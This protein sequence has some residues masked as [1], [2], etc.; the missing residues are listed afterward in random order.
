MRDATIEIVSNVIKHP[1]ADRL[2][3]CTVLGYQCVTKRDQFKVGDRV[4]YV[5]PDSV[6]P[7]S[8]WAQEYKKYSQ[9]RVKAVRLRDYWSE[10]VIIPFD[11]LPPV[12]AEAAKDCLIGDDVSDLLWISHYEPP[13]PTDLSA[14]G[15]L[16][17]G[18]PMTDEERWENFDQ[19]KLPFG[20]LVDLLLKVDGQSN[21]FYRHF[22]DKVF[23]VLGRK[24]E[25][26]PELSNNYT[27]N[28]SRYD[29]ERKLTEFSEK[30]QMS[31]VIR[32]ESYGTGIQTMEINPYSKLSNGWAMFSV[33]LIDE[34]RYARKGEPFYFLNVAKELDLPTVKLVEENVVL[35][36]EL[37]KKY[38]EELKE[39]YGK[40]FEGIVVQH[41]KG[42]FKII[43]KHYD[44]NK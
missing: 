11:A 17:Y 28:V 5:R 31:I 21:S 44:S 39:L 7:D 9:K 27:N 15:G 29:I 2:D 34:R 35:T 22:T 42:S 24:L 13:A 6:F 40:P 37:I 12:T 1:N 30:Y 32:G 38:S 25:L 4:V 16:P 43:N 10:G 8:D 18:I 33:Y 14:K 26:K 36:P 41:S 19:S 3:I 20:E 23:G